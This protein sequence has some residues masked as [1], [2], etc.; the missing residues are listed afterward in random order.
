MGVFGI[1]MAEA[2]LILGTFSIDAMDELMDYQFSAAQRYDVMVTFTEPASAGALDEVRRLPGVLAAEP[3]RSVPVRMRHGHA[4]RD[5]AITGV[6]DGARLNRV[7]DTS[8]AVVRMPAE[9]LMLSEK[10][11]EILEIRP[12]DMVT[13]EVLEGRRPVRQVMVS[14]LVDDYMGTN[15]YMDLESLHRLM[16]EGDL[17]SGAY[18]QVDSAKVDELYRQLKRTPGVAGVLLKTAAIDSF[19][20]TF[21]EMA[22][23]ITRHLHFVLR[24]HRAGRRL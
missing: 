20:E 24:H 23:T 2:L 17:L 7:V 19:K 4:E 21:A 10:L 9:G 14:R 3:F 11:A 12:G 6:L 5:L 18:L 1:A 22:A 8:F 15:A 13:V 16:Q